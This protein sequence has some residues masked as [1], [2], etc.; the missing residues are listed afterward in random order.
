MYVLILYLYQT[1]FKIDHQVP[2]L[3]AGILIGCLLAV[4]Q[5]GADARQQL[6]CAKGF[7][8]IVIGSHIQGS[9]LAAFQGSGRDNNDGHGAVCPN[10]LNDLKSIHI[11][12]AQVQ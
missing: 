8:E 2:D 1:A 5:C 12:K 6:R 9:Y 4:A 7:C 10:L 11:R 3:I